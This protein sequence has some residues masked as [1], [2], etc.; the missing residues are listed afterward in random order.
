[1][2]ESL[3]AIMLIEDG[4]EDF[5][6]LTRALQKAGINNP[7]YRFSHGESALDF[8]RG[9]GRYFKP[10][11]TTRPSLVVLDLNLPSADGRQVLKE[12]KD[13]PNLKAIPVVVLTGSR[14]PADITSCYQAGANSYILKPADMEGMV[15]LIRRL[16]HYWFDL[17]LLP[18]FAEAE[19]ATR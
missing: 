3:P 6:A 8:L 1:M 10:G 9:R 5:E 19:H 18:S 12:I 11:S 16:K 4:E 2:S 7:L 15:E 17:A 14:S 13:N